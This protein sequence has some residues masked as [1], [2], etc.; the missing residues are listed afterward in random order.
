MKLKASHYWS[1]RG[2]V[3]IEVRDHDAMVDMK[4]SILNKYAGNNPWSRKKPRVAT[5]VASLT[6]PRGTCKNDVKLAKKSLLMMHEM[7]VNEVSR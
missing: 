3:I 4:D 1:P 5:K 6:L 2:D 7:K